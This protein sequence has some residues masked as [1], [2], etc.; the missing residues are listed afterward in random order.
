[1]RIERE[2]STSLG[3]KVVLYIETPSKTDGRDEYYCQLGLE[4]G[5]VEETARIFGIDPMQALILAVSYV[6][7]FVF[8]VSRS[9]RDKTI[10]WALGEDG[11]DFGLRIAATPWR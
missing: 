7:T 2:L 9:L 1:V 8:K 6:D 3:E 4:G 10:L 5:G 11:N